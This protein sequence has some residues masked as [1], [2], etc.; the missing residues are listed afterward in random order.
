MLT[1][2]SLSA[3]GVEFVL[4]PPR[5]WYAGQRYEVAF[6]L[7]DTQQTRVLEALVLTRLTSTA[8]GAAFFP[9]DTYNHSLDFY[10]GPAVVERRRAS[11]ALRP[12]DPLM[13]DDSCNA[14][15][16]PIDRSKK[17]PRMSTTVIL[18]GESVYVITHAMEASYS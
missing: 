17:L 11:G 2:T 16:E 10:L 6:V 13:P 3:G 7:A 18:R 15:S 4:Q 12:P 9:P 1:V 8:V 5:P 14:S